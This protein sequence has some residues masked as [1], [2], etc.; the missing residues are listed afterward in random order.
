[1][2]E[3]SQYDSCRLLEIFSFAKPPSDQIWGQPS[4]H[5]QWSV[6]ALSPGL[7]WP[8]C[9]AEYSPPSGAKGKKAWS[10]TST[11]IPSW[12]AQTH[13]F[14]SIWSK[15]CIISSHYDYIRRI[16]TVMLH[17]RL[18]F[19][20]RHMPISKF[21]GLIQNRSIVRAGLQKKFILNWFPFVFFI[22]VLFLLI[23]VMRN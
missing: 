6:E 23:M 19:H 2:P 18:I 12:Y 16:N 10:Y 5:K 22:Q 7:K 17:M 15:P 4:P 8:G 21:W 11:P 14:T 9:K 3:E 1:M 20:Y 13:F